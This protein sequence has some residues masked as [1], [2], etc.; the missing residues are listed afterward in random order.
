MN[1]HR[2]TYNPKEN[3]ASLYFVGCNFRCIACYHKQLYGKI[4]LKDLKFL[5]L[6]EVIEI[7]KPVNPKRVYI[8]SGDPKPN[9]EFNHLP[10]SLYDKF[11]CEVRL[12]TN[13]YILPDLDGLTHVSISIKAVSGQL[14]KRYTGRSNEKNLENFKFI[15]G[16]GIEISASSVYIPGLIDR[17]KIERIAEFIA[18]IDRNISYRIIGYM[19]VDGLPFREPTYEEVKSVA[20]I[21]S[22]YLKN[23]TFSRPIPQDYTGIIDL[24]TNNLKRL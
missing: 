11:K 18:S 10:K 19:K 21:A 22:K 6:N 3:S 9:L 7:L 23:V 13:G 2:I 14:H 8:L 5:N 16:K 17:D 1:I 24:F 4:N 12:L 20:D 15:Y